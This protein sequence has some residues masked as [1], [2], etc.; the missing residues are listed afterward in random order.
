MKY[1]TSFYIGDKV[2]SSDSPTYFIAD[3][4]AN[5]DG[6]LA[7]AKGLI[8]KA[9][10]AGADVAKFQHFL[11]ADIVSDV[12][13]KALSGQLAHQA[14]WKK[15]VY[16]IYEQYELNR[17]WNSELA[18][19]CK[20]AKIEFMTTP[21][22]LA[23]LSGVDE[24]VNAYKIGSGD[25]T[26]CQFLERV[27]QQ[28]KPMILSTGASSLED[29][30][31]AVDA[32]L[33]H[34]DRLCILQC[35]TNYTNELSNFRYINLRVLQTFQDLYPGMPVGLSDH[36]PGHATV[37][38]AVALGGRVIEKHFTDDNER[39]GP[40]HAF[41][42]TPEAWREMVDRTRELETGLGDGTKRVEDNEKDSAVVQRRCVR[43]TTDKSAG[44]PITESDVTSLRPAPEGALAPYEL[45]ALLGATLVNDKAKGE[46]LYPD[47]VRAIT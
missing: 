12:G 20:Q 44:E 4:A 34:N 39:D 45:T 46:A 21:Y 27:A 1:Q 24:L 2:I 35:N 11:A 5:H 6:D 14:N 42:M 28:G 37:L 31:R 9:A 36:T 7:R 3:I 41:S 23:A 19:E 25:V 13:F 38:G 10:E 8:W 22:D 40:D 16:E 30:V 18:A 47:D 29:V 32:I 17:D 43:M 26:W 33:P 15:S